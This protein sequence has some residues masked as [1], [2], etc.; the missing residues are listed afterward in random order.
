MAVKPERKTGESPSKEKAEIFCFDLLSSLRKKAIISGMRLAVFLELVEIKAKTASFF[1][2]LLGVFFAFYHFGAL[3]IPTALLLY[4]AMFLFNM[5]VDA[6]D[7]YMDYHRAQKGHDYKTKTNIIGRENL[8]PTHILLL[9][10]VLFILSAGIGLCLVAKTGLPLLYLGMFSFLVGITY[11]AGPLPI[12]STPLGEV[13]SGFTM[14]FC[15]P[16]ITVYVCTKTTAIF[17]AAQL[18]RILFACI[19]NICAIAALMLANNIGDL[20]EDIINLRYTLPYYIGKP[21]AL[22]LLKLLYLGSFFAFVMGAVIKIYPL[23]MLASVLF[24]PL[25]LK[26]A[27]A[28]RAHPNKQKGFIAAVKNLFI[29]SLIQSLLF[30]IGLC[31]EK[32]IF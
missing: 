31:V 18:A 12:S 25:I 1:P 11:S 29:I 5:L 4:L 30:L 28:F 32:F 14:G 17:S 6:L 2:F 8:S 13:F 21:K 19:P 26:N 20:Q 23:T 7:N 16:L 22:G 15:I 10:V 9:I 27:A 3:D 24:L